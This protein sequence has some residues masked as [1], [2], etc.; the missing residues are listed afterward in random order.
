MAQNER[1]IHLGNVC[2]TSTSIFVFN[3]CTK[4]EQI[5][6]SLSDYYTN[7]ILPIN[8]VN[9][10][11]NIRILAVIPCISTS[12]THT[13]PNVLCSLKIVQQPGA[14]FSSVFL[15]PHHV[16]MLYGIWHF[17]CLRQV[18]ALCVDLQTEGHPS[19]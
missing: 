4:A 17:V 5:S 7:K 15:L 12:G 9:P 10:T 19:H 16:R 6:K 8:E 14:T 18:T 2:R 3:S 1:Q 11:W 13:S